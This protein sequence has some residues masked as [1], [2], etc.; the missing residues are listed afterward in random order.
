MSANFRPVQD[1][2]VVQAQFGTSIDETLSWPE[3]VSPLDLAPI[4]LGAGGERRQAMLA[5]FGLLPHWARDPTLARR[6]YNARSETAMD[7]PNFKDAWAKGQ[8]CIVPAECVFEA[9]PHRGQPTRWRMGAVD[10]SPLA[11]AG[12]WSRGWSPNGMAVMTFALLTV[13]AQHH[14]LMD[15][16][17]RTEDARLVAML[18]AEHFEAWLHAPQAEAHTLLQAWPSDR[19]SLTIAGPPPVRNPPRRISNIKG[20]ILI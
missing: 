16:L 13:D 18:D 3:E 19:L 12:L 2:E 17:Q 14:L 1:R 20:D 5:S 7:K 6:T 10:G 4:V 15:S 9:G 8:R 11:L